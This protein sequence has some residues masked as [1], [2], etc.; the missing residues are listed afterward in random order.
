VLYVVT[1][2]YRQ[3]RDEP[4]RFRLELELPDVPEYSDQVVKGILNGR[5]I[6]YNELRTM[7]DMKLCQL[8]WVYDVN[9]ALTL[10]RIKQRNLLEKLVGFLPETPDVEM[11]KK[12]VFGYVDSR[13]ENDLN[14]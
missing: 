2:Y 5:R 9:F 14:I 1:E 12:K 7:N 13:I 3:Y 6:D 11:L 4:G 10:K 8:G